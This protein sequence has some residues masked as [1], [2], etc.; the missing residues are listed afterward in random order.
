MTGTEVRQYNLSE[1]PAIP[2]REL[3]DQL[4]VVERDYQLAGVENSY[5]QMAITF[6]WRH[7]HNRAYRYAYHKGWLG[8]IQPDT[9]LAELVS[10]WVDEY[11]CLNG[12]YVRAGYLSA[13]VLKRTVDTGD[14]LT[15]PGVGLRTFELSSRAVDHVL[16]KPELDN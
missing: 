15:V 12:L 9:E 5:S 10:E 7:V 13:S 2:A 4:L 3:D 8:R 16:S 6:A 1:D 14:L 11:K